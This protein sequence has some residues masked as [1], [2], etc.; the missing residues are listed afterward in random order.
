MIEGPGK[1]TNDPVP[2][3]RTGYERD[4][5]KCASMERLL[6]DAHTAAAETSSRCSG[7]VSCDA[8]VESASVAERISGVGTTTVSSWE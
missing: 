5:C 3:E 4:S 8:S 2:N 6:F 7:M 1:R